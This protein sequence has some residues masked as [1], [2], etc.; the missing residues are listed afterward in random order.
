MSLNIQAKTG[1]NSLKS[2]PIKAQK[3]FA[4][5]AEREPVIAKTTKI[6]TN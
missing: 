3:G 6:I 5:F 1:F 4:I 2:N